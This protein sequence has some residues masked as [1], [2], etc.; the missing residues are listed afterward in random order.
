MNTQLKILLYIGLVVGIIYLIQNKYSVFDISF[1]KPRDN[2][3][4]E[5]I[6]DENEGDSLEIL[7][8]DGQ[9]IFVT[10]EVS[11]TPELRKQGLSNRE[12]LGDYQ[13]ML[14][15]FDTQ[16]N[17]SF[18][19][20]DMLIPLDI[21][22]ISYSGYIVDVKENLLPC[23]SDKCLSISS[24]EPFMYALE[25][26][27]GFVDINKIAVGNAVLFNISSKE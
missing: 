4:K 6:N 14:F 9:K 16:G 22:F 26:N 19:M 13:G 11:D 8:S 3:V 5:D 7:N 1:D 27:S 17:Y 24:D 10:L 25:V 12:Q 20:K 15:V 18:W 21:I 23:S 2:K